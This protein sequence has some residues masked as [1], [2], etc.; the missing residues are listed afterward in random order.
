MTLR[1]LNILAVAGKLGWFILGLVVLRVLLPLL[2]GD[3]AG[4]V[5]IAGG[6]FTTHLV[7]GILL[8]AGGLAV[9]FSRYPGLLETE[10][11]PYLTAMVAF[12]CAGG[13]RARELCQ[14]MP[15]EIEPDGQPNAAGIPIGSY[16]SNIVYHLA[17]AHYLRGEWSEACDVWA[18]GRALNST[19]DDRLCSST[20][21]NYLALCRAGQDAQG[22]VL[23]EAV[24]RPMQVIENE[25]Y[26]LLCLMFRGERTGEQVLLDV[27]PGTTEFATR[28]YGIAC[29]QRLRGDENAARELLQRIVSS[30]PRN[31]FG[32]IAAE[33]DL[34]R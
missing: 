23:L 32:C 34:A 20:Y 12:I 25:S 9:Y 17:L 5:G 2:I 14:S 1:M 4:I 21:W 19:N 27:K 16:Q 15:D 26:Q 31:A 11:R 30:G 33:V 10:G 7:W 29:W 22:K 8:V 24:A 3:F 6:L 28:G 13:T 18:R